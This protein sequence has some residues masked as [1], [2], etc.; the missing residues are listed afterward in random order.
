MEFYLLQFAL[1]LVY[2]TLF[3]F[4]LK[5][6]PIYYV[7]SILHLSL[8]LGLRSYT[9]GTDT[10]QYV[11]F[12][13]NQINFNGNG[14]AIYIFLEKIIWRLFGPNYHV[15]LFILSTITIILIVLAFS[16]FSRRYEFIFLN[17]YIFISYYFY[18]ESFNAQRQF[19]A[20]SVTMIA[21]VLL[22][23]NR[24]LLSLLLIV[25]ATGIH[26]TAIIMLAAYPIKYI[27]KT[28]LN[29]FLVCI[30]SAIFGLSSNQLTVF[31]SHLFS[32]Y[33]MYTNAIGLSSRGGSFFLGLFI[34]F[35]LIL[36]VYFSDIL[37]DQE[38]SFLV[39]LTAIGSILYMVGMQSQLI[40]RVA[41]YFLIYATISIPIVIYK[42]SKKFIQSKIV[43]LF[44]SATVMIAGIVILIYKLSGNFGEIIP[45][46]L[47]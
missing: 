34:F 44:L 43:Y 39:F 45:Y 42:V 23:K 7:I 46:T 30:I 32:H 4:I 38:G 37:K 35:M 21:L 47:H 29:F 36:G 10:A 19:L 26:S 33:N 12:Y 6:R 1:F 15:F 31:F 20:I 28:K 11:S 16:N 14:S 25:L 2:T 5:N 3:L 24:W 13:N 17:I 18:F 27:K 41:D 9:V 22:N 8:L 40:I